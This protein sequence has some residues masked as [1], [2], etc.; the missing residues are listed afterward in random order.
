MMKILVT[1]EVKYSYYIMAGI[2][3]VMRAMGVRSS[4]LQMKLIPWRKCSTHWHL[5]PCGQRCI[6]ERNIVITE[7]RFG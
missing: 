5:G 3:I 1:S 7:N 4:G 6:E 2:F